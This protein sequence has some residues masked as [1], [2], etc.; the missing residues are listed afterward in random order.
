MNQSSSGTNPPCVALGFGPVVGAGFGAT[1][2]DV[3]TGGAVGWY[4]GV[5]VADAGVVALVVG[6]AAGVAGAIGVEAEV[7]AGG[8]ARTATVGVAVAVRGVGCAA[9][10][11]V[12]LGQVACAVCVGGYV[13]P[14][15][16]P[17]ANVIPM[18]PAITIPCNAPRRRGGGASSNVGNV[19]ICRR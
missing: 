15:P 16:Q 18:A 4:G 19:G 10:T 12:R 14:N 8:T 9:A 11:L 2:L 6:T 7:S 17:T 5:A 1:T 13:R 3:L